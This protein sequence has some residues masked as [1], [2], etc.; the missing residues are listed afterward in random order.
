MN[1]L[2][3]MILFVGFLILIFLL[4]MNTI[5]NYQE[6]EDWFKT[7]SDFIPEAYDHEKLM[8]TKHKPRKRELYKAF[9]NILRDRRTVWEVKLR[10]VEVPRHLKSF[11]PWVLNVTNEELKLMKGICKTLER[12]GYLTEL[13]EMVNEPIVKLKITNPKQSEHRQE[14]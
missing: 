14:I 1:E 2:I 9:G 7:N 12:K 3:L 5:R 11:D 10:I 6:K 4:L 8:V 13:G